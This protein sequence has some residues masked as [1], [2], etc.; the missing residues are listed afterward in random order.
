MS[1]EQ[2]LPENNVPV[3]EDNGCKYSNF[4]KYDYI[5]TL[6]RGTS[7]QKF[8]SNYSCLQRKMNLF[9]YKKY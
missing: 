4:Q 3:Q 7:C 9:R 6:T 2:F 5:L 1:S 8:I